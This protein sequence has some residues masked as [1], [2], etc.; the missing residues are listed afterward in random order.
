MSHSLVLYLDKYYI[1]GAICSDDG[2]CRVVPSNREDRFWLYFHE[3]IDGEHIIYGKRYKRDFDSGTLHYYGDVFS[4]ITGK[5][6]KFKR[7]GREQELHKIF[8]ASSIIDELKQAIDS[9]DLVPI[10]T[11]LSFS[12]DISYAARII[13]IQDVLQPEGF[14]IKETGARIDHLALEHTFRARQYSQ[15]G[16]YLL[17]NAC[18]ENLHYALYKH[19]GD[20]LIRVSEG[21]LEGLGIDLTRRALLE[22]ILK[23]VNETQLVVITEDEYKAEYLYLENYVEEWLSEIQQARPGLP[24]KLTNITLS[25]MSD[26][27]YDIT[28]LRKDI[29][30]RSRTIIEDIIREISSSVAREIAQDELKGILFLGNTFENSQFEQTLLNKYPLPSEACI[31]Y[32][33][34]DLSSIIGVYPLMDCSQFSEE[35]QSTLARGEDELKRQNLA[36]EEERRKME[37]ERSRSEQIEAE[38]QAFETKKNYEEAMANVADYE[39]QGEYAQMLDWAKIALDHLPDSSE[40]KNK[41]EESTRLLS[42]MKVREEQYKTSMLKAQ[43]SFED[44]LW[45]DALAQAEIALSIKPDSREASRIK[46]EA[47]KLLKRAEQIDKFLTKAETYLSQK[48]YDEAHKEIQKVLA[49]DENNKTALDLAANIDLAIKKSRKKIDSLKQELSTATA[50]GDLELAISLTNK[51]IDIDREH[52]REWTEQSQHFKAEQKRLAQ[53]ETEWLSLKEQMDQ[54]LFREQWDEVVR[55]GEAALKLREEPHLR[56]NLDRAKL[57]L[58]MMRQQELYDQSISQVKSYIVDKEWDRAKQMLSELQSQYPD[59]KESFRQLFKQIFAGES[60]DSK[61]KASREPRKVQPKAEV[62]D[63]FG[64]TTSTVKKKFTHDDFNF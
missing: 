6:I 38:R 36:K 16:H 45:S 17:L 26:N 47:S 15:D 14:D 40:A 29:E 27:P 30:E 62:D 57:K 58:D 44:D 13:F 10:E 9:D 52:Q 33:E 21:C 61:L 59:R 25:K 34:S 2:T 20:I 60:I 35:T 31:H 32:T 56:A 12:P 24:V 43:K 3:D 37:A 11:Y 5:E 28:L 54:A 22:H 8:K 42:E 19:T 50:T 46:S 41:I 49:L 1:V 53:E 39:K 55:L 4:C 7:Y 64:S 63:F 18:N 23:K 48:A 51:L